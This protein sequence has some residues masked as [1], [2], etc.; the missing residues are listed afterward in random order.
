MVYFTE[1]KKMSVTLSLR[2]TRDKRKPGVK[3]PS[4]K[5]EN[6]QDVVERLSK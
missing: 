5:E 1:I 3:L 2:V 4:T 6:I